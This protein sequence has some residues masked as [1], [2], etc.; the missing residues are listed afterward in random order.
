MMENIPEKDESQQTNIGGDV[1][2]GGGVFNTGRVETQGG[3]FVG[4]DQ[5]VHLHGAEFAGLGSFGDGRGRGRCDFYRH[6]RLP[7]NYVVRDELLEE[8]RDL[9]LRSDGNVAMTSSIL[10]AGALFGMGGIGKT[11]VARTLCDDG[12]VQAAFPDGILWATLGQR[13]DLVAR[14]REWVRVLGGAVPQTV[15]TPEE[16]TN[17]LADSLANRQCL[18]IVDDVWER[19]Q[20]ACFLVDVPGCRVLFTTRNAEIATEVGAKVL[21]VPVM[22]MDQAIELLIEWSGDS[23]RAIERPRQE[24]IVTRL[25]RLPLAIKLA[26]EQLRRRSPDEWLV[27]FDTQKLRKRRPKELHDDLETLLSGKG[28][29]DKGQT[30]RGGKKNPP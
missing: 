9:L 7:P 25:G 6:V 17:V 5:H 13:P 2:T 30:E 15:L 26:G 21:P 27:S 12:A 1:D 22:S 23:I 24:E 8:I 16:L 28:L 20:L 19:E 18:L 14:L 11:V 29:S 3:D 4:G 10:Q